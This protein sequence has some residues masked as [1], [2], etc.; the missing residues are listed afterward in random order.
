[1]YSQRSSPRR[2]I[3]STQLRWSCS[4]YITRLHLP[5][6]LCRLQRLVGS[7]V[8]LTSLSYLAAILLIFSV[9]GA[10]FP[11][12]GSGCRVHRI[13]GQ[14]HKLSLLASFTIIFCFPFT[15][16]VTAQNMNYTVLIVGAFTIFVGLYWFAKRNSFAGPPVAA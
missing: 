13:R 10:G 7:F 9:A 14:H 16:P 12:D 5:R 11:K 6:L 4:E 3:L 15:L 1:M 8:V 2:R